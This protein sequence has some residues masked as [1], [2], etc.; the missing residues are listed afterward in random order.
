MKHLIDQESQLEVHSLSDWQ[1]VELRPQHWHD[2]IT[3]TSAGDKS[4]CHVLDPLEVP[5]QTVCDAA[6]QSYSSQ[7]EN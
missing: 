4:R 5:E 2:I 7:D 3:S 1:P 6:E